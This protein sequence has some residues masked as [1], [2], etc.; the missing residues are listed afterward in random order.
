MLTAYKI[1]MIL[2]SPLLRVYLHYRA[3]KGKEVHARLNEKY[4]I[5]SQPR[6]NKDAPLMWIH[7]AS[8]G[9]AQSALI[10]IKKLSH[11]NPTLNFLVTSVTTTSAALLD[12][13]LPENAVHQFVPIDHPRWIE[14]FLNHWQPTMVLFLESEIWPNT[15]MAVKDKEIPMMLINAR[16]SDKSFKTWLK[17]KDSAEQIFSAFDRILAQ[18]KSD[19]DHFIALG[20]KAKT[21]GNIKLNSDPL[22]V[23]LEDL[24][25]FNTSIKGRPVWLYASTHEGEEELAAAMH[26]E[27]KDKHPTLLTI[28]VPRHP[29]RSGAIKTKLETMGQ[30][31]TT[32]DADL[33]LPTPETDIYLANTL[34]E[35]GL[36]YRA[37]PLSMIADVFGICCVSGK[38]S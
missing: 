22:P 31:V 4:G 18:T 30:V 37:S 24:N 17:I 3:F 33:N 23:N 35:L 13:K 16:L 11:H 5:A 19:T 7:A 10:L 28:I 36:F 21:A 12:K 38:R 20:G 15:I 14:R 27:L 1:L 9:E 29:I 25:A 6:P 26:I 34:G 8:V 32:R 2:T